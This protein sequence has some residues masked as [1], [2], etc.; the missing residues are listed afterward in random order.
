[1]NGGVNYLKFLISGDDSELDAALKK[2]RRSV[3]GYVDDITSSINKA[4]AAFGGLLAGVSV[5]GVVGKLVSVQREFDV[6]NSSL[7]TVTGSSKAAAREMEWLKQFAKETPYGLS[8]A[9]EGFVKMKALGLNPTRESLTSFG[10][11][12]SAMGKDL[13]QMIEAVADASTGEF[14][15]LKEFGVKSSK[16][17]ES[18]KFTFQGVTTTVR[19]SSEEITAYLEAIGNNQFASAMSER[20]KTLDGA[21]AAL[22]DSWDELFRTVNQNNTGGFIYDTVTLANA[23]L[24]DLNTILQASNEVMSEG[25]SSGGAYKTV[26]EGLATV[27]ET[28]AVLGTNVKYV[29]TGIGTE[30]GGLAAQAAAVA[31]GDFAGAAEIHR[32]MVADAKSARIAVDAQTEAILSAR[33]RAADAVIPKPRAGSDLEFIANSVSGYKPLTATDASLKNMADSLLKSTSGFKSAAESMGEVRKKGDEI[34]AMLKRLKEQDLGDSPQAKQLEARLVGVKEKLKSMADKADDGAKS[35]K[36]LQTA[37]GN[38][39]GTLDEKIALEKVDLENGQK[40]TESEKLRIKFQQEL[41]GSLKGLTSAQKASINARLDELEAL[42]KQSTAAKELAKAWQEDARA[43]EAL[44][45][46]REAA[47]KSVQDSILKLQQEEE[48]YSLAAE[49][50]ISLAEAMERLTIARLQDHLA[51]ARSGAESQ[52]TIDALER[53]LAARQKLLGVIQSKDVR[54]ANKK[55]TEEAAKDWDKF[56]QTISRTLADYIMAGGKDAATYLKRLF[57]TL[58]LEP[59]VQTAVGTLM[60]VKDPTGGRGGIDLGGGLTDWSTW[61]SK[62]ADWLFDQGVGMSFRGFEGLGSSMQSLGVTVGRLDTALK[63]LPGMSGGIGSAA[64][65]LGSI[66]ALTQGKVGTG[67]GSA[68]GTW[69]LPGIG[70]MVGGFLGGL[71]DDLFGDDDVPRFEAAA[72]YKDGKTAKGW[73]DSAEWSDA[74]YP[75][76]EGIAGSI[77]SALDATA[78]LFGKTAGYQ[79]WT[80]FSKDAEDKG[81]F[82]VL[83]IVGPDG[84]NLVDWSQYDKEWGGR[85]FSDGDAGQKEYLAAVATDVKVAFKEMGM[86]QWATQILDAANDLQSLNAA[87]QQIGATKVVFDQLGASMQIFAGISGDLQTQLL[88]TAGSMDALV[89]YANT[90]NEGFYSERERMDRLNGQ[91]ATGLHDLGY[92]INPYIAGSKEAFRQLVEAAMESGQGELAVKLMAM[93]GSFRTAADYAARVAEEAAKAAEEAEKKARS[94]ALANVEAAVEREK[95][96][97]SDIQSSAQ[98]AIS[99]LSSTLQLLTSNSRE[100]Y[101]TVDSTRQML[102]AQGSAYI[103]DALRGVRAGRK[104]TDYDGLGDAISAAREGISGGVY[105]SQFERERDALVLAGQ[106]SELGDLTGGQLSVQERILKNAQEQLDSLDKT[107]AACRDLVEGNSTE[108]DVMLSVDQAVRALHA[109][110]PGLKKPT[111]TTP[112]N[113]GGS[114]GGATFGGGGS[115]AAGGVVWGAAPG[116]ADGRTYVDLEA[117]TRTYGDG[118]VERLSADEIHLMQLQRN[119]WSGVPQFAAGGYHGGGWRIVG[120]EG[121][122]L[123]YTGPSRIFSAMQTRQMFAAGGDDSSTSAINARIDYLFEQYGSLAGI[124]NT[125]LANIDRN[126]QGLPQMVERFDVVTASGVVRTRDVGKVTA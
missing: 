5:V 102:A 69:A 125:R 95:K 22:G 71:L 18:V 79:L 40:A 110:V 114:S 98:T 113:Q 101:G 115:G 56:S 57:A 41:Q 26:Q 103:Q 15:R 117:G 12:A 122:E 30:L 80:A 25:A 39:L 62:G 72:Q 14:E 61:G 55:A 88:A 66:Y 86:A 81:T 92:E 109:L 16:E 63:G 89:G 21:I 123:E 64:G 1:M 70:T 50:G 3:T 75:L 32:Q 116:A 27:F 94:A 74:F 29:L 35:A 37:Y 126:T 45:Q 49:S 105:A 8:Q 58:V 46:R 59:T 53:E 118:S 48:A 51:M 31:R 2:S 7:V 4:T 93:S 10:N 19:N 52:A 60:G 11:T 106:L 100:L 78:K 65:Y 33:K 99:S 17:G 121:P 124:L 108:I 120:E 96:Y 24:E 20:A 43:M 87:L 67:I 73:T 13:M 107:L 47:V 91:V 34:S 42:E 28:V 97:W 119:G 111:A 83:S 38:F 76:V 85:W 23:A 112:A 68:I 9:T 36:Q 77:G 90:F 82:G 6:L 54:E 44:A 84:K 104:V